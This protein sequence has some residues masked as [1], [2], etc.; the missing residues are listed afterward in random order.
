MIAKVVLVKARLRNW[1]VET[2]LWWM[3]GMKEWTLLL[4]RHRHMSL[5]D[6]ARSKVA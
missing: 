2:M 1:R 5:S 4:F 3:N 6:D